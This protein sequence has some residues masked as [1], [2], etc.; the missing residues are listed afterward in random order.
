MTA[1]LFISL[2]VCFGLGMPIAFSLGVSSVA[3]LAFGSTLP[4][5]L[6]AQRLFAG[7][8][9]F[10]LMASPF[11]MLAG[12]LMEN[13][14]IS[15]RLVDFAHSLVGGIFG[16]LG[17]V[18]VLA[19]MF[20]AGISGA[21]AA[22]TAAVGAVSIPAM[23][24]KGYKKGFAAAI[25]AAGGSI[26]VIIPPSIPMII[27]GVVGGVSIGKM[28]LGGFVPGVLIGGGL[29]VASYFLAKKAGYK[30][31]H[32]SSLKE[33]W[34]Y[35]ADAFWALLMPGIILG[36]ILGGVFTPTEA[37]VVA[38][39][40]GLIVGLFIYKELS[41]K[42][43]PK[44][45]AKAAVSTSTVML[46][47]A[48]ASI[49]GWILTAEQVPQNVAAYLTTLTESPMVLYALVL[50]MLLVVG[51][52]METSASLII[53]TPVFLPVVKQFGIDPVHFGVVMVTALA[54]GM[55]TP[56]LG[57]CLFISCNIAR[58]QLTEIVGFVWPLLGIMIAILLL[59]TFI[60]GLVMFVPNM[61]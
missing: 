19:A 8:D 21:A 11:F 26:G 47:I 54:I 41:I 52:F 55:L 17:M 22:D 61:F 23:I 2:I 35:F 56:P 12:A 24:R 46:L 34:K 9:S 13:G 6:A 48:T 49:F 32:A 60:P 28:F 4:L 50:V 58:I 51:T 39:V 31:D 37:A 42:D 29:M 20:F 16:G 18:A 7:T 33:V 45:F 38:A 44:I 36:G 3:T 10:P 30:K 25:Q 57:I 43:L 15:R 27:Y 59:I 5:T 40:Y 1:I 14:G 53:L